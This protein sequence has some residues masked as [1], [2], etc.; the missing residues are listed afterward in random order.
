MVTA[1]DAQTREGFDVAGFMKKAKTCVGFEGKVRAKFVTD[2]ARASSEFMEGIPTVHLPTVDAIQ[3]ITGMDRI[4]AQSKSKAAILEEL[5]HLKLAKPDHDQ[6]M[7]RCVDVCVRQV[8]DSQEQEAVRGKMERFKAFAEVAKE[9][10][11]TT[12]TMG[13]MTRRPARFP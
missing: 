1:G 12:E 2:R 4:S 10:P 8:L 9:I 13:V 11:P 3:R 5:C 6:E 7:F